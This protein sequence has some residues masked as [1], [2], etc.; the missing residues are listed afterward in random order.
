MLGSGFPSTGQ[1]SDAKVPT[2]VVTFWPLPVADGESK[3]HKRTGLVNHQG[4]EDIS[5]FI[6][7]LFLKFYPPFF[8]SVSTFLQKRS[9]NNFS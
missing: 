2:V 7:L 1:E 8:S 6:F 5:L 9:K 4:F 3:K